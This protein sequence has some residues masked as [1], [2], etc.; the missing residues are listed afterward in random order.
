MRFI[1]INLLIIGLFAGCSQPAT[2][3]KGLKDIFEGDFYIGASLNPSHYKGKD[4]KGVKLIKREFNTATI[5]NSMKWERI[6]PEPNVYDFENADKFVAFTEANDLYSVGHVLVWH[7]QTPDWVFRD[8]NGEL[9]DREALLERMRDHIHTVVGRY[10]GRIDGWDVVNE[11]IS[12][13]GGVMR[14]SLWYQI[15]GEDFAAKAFEYAAEADPNANLYYNDYSLPDPDKR[16]GAYRLVKSIQDQ[17]IKVTGVG[18]QGHYL[19]DFPS[20]KELDDAISRF[21]ELGAV[22]ITELDL[23]ILPARYQGADVGASMDIEV[24]EELDPY[25]DGLPDSVNQRH[26]ERYAQLFRIFLKHRD[27]INRVTFWNLTDKDSWK[28]NFPI[29]GRTNYPL[30]FD[31]NYQPKL[32]YDAIIQEKRNLSE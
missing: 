30:I 22:A 19:W 31:R 20:E 18:M 2:Q 6:H 23:D 16:E 17:G 11:A 27:V 4:Q 28:N 21:S 15:I 10:K 24:S 5:E 7:S 3:E 8:D 9:L 1:T 29:P 12:D 13:S 25:A 26:A 32:A 14:N